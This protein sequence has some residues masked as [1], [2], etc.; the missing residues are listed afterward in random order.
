MSN[1]SEKHRIKEA[2]PLIW[3]A[4]F[5]QAMKEGAEKAKDEEW[6]EELIHNEE[7]VRQVVEGIIEEKDFKKRRKMDNRIATINNKIGFSEFFGTGYNPNKAVV[8]VYSCIE[9]MFEND[10]LRVNDD[11][12]NFIEQVV[13]NLLK[14]E[15]NQQ[16]SDEEAE[17]IRASGIKKGKKMFNKLKEML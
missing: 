17:K 8:E 1:R 4:L 15:V 12:R 11:Y 9:T 10:Y 2:L 6:L 5:Y 16:V 14:H 7:S 3:C 13:N